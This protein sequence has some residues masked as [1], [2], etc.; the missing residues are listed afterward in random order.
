VQAALSQ[1]GEEVCVAE[2]APGGMAAFRNSLARSF[3]FKAYVR[4]ALHLAG[5]A[6]GG[7]AAALSWAKQ[8]ESAVAAAQR[9]PASGVQFHADAPPDAIVGEP[10]QHRAADLQVLHRPCQRTGPALPHCVS[11]L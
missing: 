5:V 1:V 9:P 4:T 2:G 3:L 11:I 6:S 7:A 8:E 10:R